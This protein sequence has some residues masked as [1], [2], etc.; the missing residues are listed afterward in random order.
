MIP[1]SSH[2]ISALER[3]R[4]LLCAFHRDHPDR[5]EPETSSALAGGLA[6]IERYKAFRDH[7]EPL[8]ELLEEWLEGGECFCA[9]GIAFRGPCTFCKTK[10]LLLTKHASQPLPRA[11]DRLMGAAQQ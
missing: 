3:T 5:Y 6:V 4:D 1:Y 10:A 9:E 8:M 2:A 11:M 7:P